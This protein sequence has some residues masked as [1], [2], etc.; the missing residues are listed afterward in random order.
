MRARLPASAQPGLTRAGP[1]RLV[2]LRLADWR[3]GECQSHLWPSV[4]RAGPYGLP[5]CPSSHGPALHTPGQK[6][7]ERGPRDPIRPAPVHRAERW[8]TPIVSLD[9]RLEEK[10]E[11]P[12]AAKASRPAQDLVS[13]FA[14]NQTARARWDFAPFGAVMKDAPGFQTQGDVIYR[15][16]KTA[17]APAVAGPPVLAALKITPPCVPNPVG[18]VTVAARLLPGPQGQPAATAPVPP[19]SFTPAPHSAGLIS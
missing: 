5:C 14:G 18:P 4:F 2:P 10:P 7:E 16:A 1:A 3:F 9:R 19:A 15:A 13:L 17:P 6:C 12:P 11:R 8:G